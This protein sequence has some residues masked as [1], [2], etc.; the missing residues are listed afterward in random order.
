MMKGTERVGGLIEQV[1]FQKAGKGLLCAKLMTLILLQ[2][3]VC[4]TKPR[5]S[6]KT[7]QMRL[8]LVNLIAKLIHI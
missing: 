8:K 6:R 4:K 3:M 7:T 1:T 5:H 2:K